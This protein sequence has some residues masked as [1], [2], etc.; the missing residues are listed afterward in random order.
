MRLSIVPSPTAYTEDVYFTFFLDKYFNFGNWNDDLQSNKAWLNRSFQQPSTNPLSSL[1]IRCLVSAFFSNTHESPQLQRD[2][3][4][5]YGKALFALHKSIE[6]EADFDLLSAV[7]VLGLYESCVYTTQ[8]AWRNH[9]RAL[10][11]LV[12]SKGSDYFRTRPARSLLMWTR[13]T[14][15]LESIVTRTRCF[16]EDSEW[17]QILTSDDNESS[18]TLKLGDI[19]VVMG[20]ICEG[21]KALREKNVDDVTAEASELLDRLS[22]LLDDLHDWWVA[23]SSD[24]TR[25]PSRTFPT[26]QNHI[27]GPPPMPG[28]DTS[29]VLGFT[30]LEAASGWCRYHTHVI[31][32]MHWIQKLKALNI[33]SLSADI[34]SRGL[35][36]TGSLEIEAHAFAICEA[37]YFYSLPQHCHLGSVYV[38]LPARVSWQA[39]PPNSA[40]THWIEEFMNSISHTGGFVIP[41][42]A[43]KEIVT[44]E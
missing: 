27:E 8:A 33:P 6:G 13:Y 32:A 12:Q 41:K 40:Y 26:E 16:L 14:F 38:T 31:L 37:L 19:V 24:P 7:A 35:V 25:L 28:M 39:L 11:R 34:E 43:L 18:W 21:V 2:A 1:A 9:V 5:L 29:T 22:E 10:K 17:A 3:F 36:R 30:N 44:D 4:K 15:I 23:W 42:H 20:G